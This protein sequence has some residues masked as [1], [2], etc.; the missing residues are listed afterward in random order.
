MVSTCSYNKYRNLIYL[1]PCSYSLFMHAVDVLRLWSGQIHTTI[2]PTRHHDLPP[3]SI[4]ASAGPPL[5]SISN[6]VQ[7]VQGAKGN[8]L[9]LTELKRVLSKSLSGTLSQFCSLAAKDHK[10]FG[11]FHRRAYRRFRARSA[12]AAIRFSLRAAAR[13]AILFG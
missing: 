2:G 5:S 12:I 1:T 10:R 4:Q 6:N 7:R 13:R 11:I 8:L 9:F 3:H